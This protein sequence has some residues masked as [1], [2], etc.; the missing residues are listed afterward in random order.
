MGYADVFQYAHLAEH[1]RY[2]EGAH[3]PQ[4]GDPAGRQLADGLPLIQIRVADG[5]Q[6]EGQQI[7]GRGFAGT[8]GA[9]QGMD[10][11]LPHLKIDRIH[12][13]EAIELLGQAPGFE[14]D[15]AHRF[16]SCLMMVCLAEQP[17]ACLGQ[18]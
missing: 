18:P 1:G 8:V 17:R 11:P 4:A 15:I 5:W 9:D 13:S 14:N 12:S 16:P 3:Q 2:L 10:M 7:E 6:E